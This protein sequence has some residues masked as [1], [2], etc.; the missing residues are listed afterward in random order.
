MWSDEAALD[1]AARRLDDWEAGFA[2][3]AQRARSLAARMRK[4]TGTAQ[5][6][7]RSIT[8]TVDSSGRLLD[9]RLDESTRQHSA[10]HTA[11][12]VLATTR[13]AHADLLR[14]VTDAT[15]DTLGDDP[16]GQAVIDAYRPGP[17]GTGA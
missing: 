1:A 2:D 13:A 3:R 5:S 9:L 17:G 8:A 10:A 14:Q 15:R 12:Q 11:R 16:A 7:D 6:P 4:L